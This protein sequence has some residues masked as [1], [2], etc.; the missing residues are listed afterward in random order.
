MIVKKYYKAR[1]DEFLN[2]MK[3]GKACRASGFNFQKYGLD[4]HWR[5]DNYLYKS[6]HIQAIVDELFSQR[7]RDRQNMYL[8]DFKDIERYNSKSGF[9]TD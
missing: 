5:Y 2:L 1:K 3:I 4:S 9:L 8:A 6:E 7:T